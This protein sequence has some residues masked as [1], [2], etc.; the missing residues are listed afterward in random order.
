MDTAHFFWWEMVQWMVELATSHQICFCVDGSWSVHLPVFVGPHGWMD[1]GMVINGWW[2]GHQ[3][4]FLHCWSIL[5]LEYVVSSRILFLFGWII[6]WMVDGRLLCLFEWTRSSIETE[7]KCD[8][9]PP[10][11]T[12]KWTSTKW[13]LEWPSAV[14]LHCWSILLLE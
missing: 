6:P 1:G 12:I 10:I 5:L 7:T 13:V 11:Q 14:F 2:D 9:P 8:H 4:Y 3:L